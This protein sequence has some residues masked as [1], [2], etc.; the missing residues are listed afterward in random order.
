M[1]FIV[2]EV[3]KLKDHIR[4]LRYSP[5]IATGFFHNAV[6]AASRSFFN[7]DLTGLGRTLSITLADRDRVGEA[8]TGGALVGCQDS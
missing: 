8:F 2:R 3:L 1:I 4:Y 6:F 7:I 5:F